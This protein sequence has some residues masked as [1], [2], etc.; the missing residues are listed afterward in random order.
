VRV[1]AETRVSIGPGVSRTPQPAA[2]AIDAMTGPRY[3]DRSGKAPM[4]ART[5]HRGNIALV[6]VVRY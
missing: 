4:I 5:R 6:V 2:S 3:E 1:S